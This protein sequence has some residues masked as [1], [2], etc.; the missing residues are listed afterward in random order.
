MSSLNFKTLK[1]TTSLSNFIDCIRIAEFTG[2]NPSPQ[3]NIC[4][5]GLPGIVFHANS[6]ESLQ[7]SQGVLTDLPEL[8]LYGQVTELSKMTFKTSHFTTFQVLLKPF[9]LKSLFKINAAKLTNNFLD[10]KKFNNSPIVQLQ[11]AKN[12]DQ[13]IKILTDFLQNLSQSVQ[14][15]SEISQITDFID[16]NLSQ[17]SVADLT[18][19]FN[20]SERQLQKKFQQFIGL[21]PVQYIRIRRFNRAMQMMDSGEY[22]LLS[23]IAFALDFHDQSHF[24]RDIKT[25][26]G[27]TPKSI[28]QKTTEFYH[29]QVGATFL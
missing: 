10:L 13:V 19:T 25:F 26:S 14:Q 28:T 16:S 17:V 3:I 22:E 4:P 9:S 5:N 12:N 15:D 21:P 11:S 6:I 8:F 7:T 2:D 20:I 18:D 27:K 24:I 1:P 23:D 29:D